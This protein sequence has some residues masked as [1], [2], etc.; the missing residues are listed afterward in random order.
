M[1]AARPPELLILHKKQQTMELKPGDKAPDF[2]AKDQDGKV[3]TL[4]DYKGRKV[5]LYFYPKDNT[6]TCTT[7]ACN[8]RDNYAILKKKGIVVLGVSADDEKSHKKFEKKYSL[9]FTLLAD[10]DKKIVNDYGIWALKKFMGLTFMGI[11]RKT[12]LIDENGKI[13]HII[14]KVKSKEHTAQILETWGLS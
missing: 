13:A 12:F 7:E 5:V 3:H 10:T 6:Q 4:K 8:L 9:P 11:L 14:D 1:F 2:T